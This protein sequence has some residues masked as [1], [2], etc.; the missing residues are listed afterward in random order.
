MEVISPEVVK[1]C[2]GNKF[3]N[4]YYVPSV[5]T[6]GGVLL[7]WD[8]LVV[9]LSRLHVTQNTI[10]ALVQQVE[11]PIWWITWVYGPQGNTEKVVFIAELGDV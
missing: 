10:T 1:Q 5:G 2:L 3:E 8:T 9:T 4:F 7:A 11:G 6:R